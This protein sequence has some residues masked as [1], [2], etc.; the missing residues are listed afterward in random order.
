MP[1]TAQQLIQEPQNLVTVQ[2]KDPLKKALDLMIENDFS[3]LP[4]IHSDLIFQGMIS[5]DGIVKAVSH[6]GLSLDQLKVSHASETAII[7]RQDDEISEILKGLKERNAIAIVNKNHELK[8]IVTSYDTTEY[9]R[10]RAEDIMLAEDIETTLRDFIE[11]AHYK[12][13]GDLDQ[14]KLSNSIEAITSSGKDL[15][16]K[17]KNAVCKYL[18]STKSDNLKPNIPLIDQVF[19]ENIYQPIRT[20]TFEELTLSEYIALFKNIWTQYQSTFNEMKWGNFSK[21]AG[22][23]G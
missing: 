17:F 2:M 5:S 22:N 14:E 19:Q 21:S 20:K 18:N 6:F 23:A 12:P 16:S 8:G 4:V 7:Y 13:D 11:A 3:Q 1:F 9:F 10:R 15:Q